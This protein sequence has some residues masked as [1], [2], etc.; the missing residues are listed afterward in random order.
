MR[1]DAAYLPESWRGAIFLSTIT[2][3]FCVHIL[4]S[5][6]HVRRDLPVS[7]L[8]ARLVT[9]APKKKRGRDMSR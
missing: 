3:V 4:R 1:R 7:R 5:E 6:T 9:E 2:Y 8:Q